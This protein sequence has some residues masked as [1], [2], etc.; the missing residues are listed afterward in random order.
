V[1]SNRNRRECNGFDRRNY[2]KKPA[3]EI[4]LILIVRE[5]S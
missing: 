5:R 4:P 1:T 3:H 2:R